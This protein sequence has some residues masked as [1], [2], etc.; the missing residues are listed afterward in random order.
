M[1]ATPAP[2]ICSVEG[3]GAPLRATN[4]IGRC[5]EHAYVPAAGAVCGADGCGTVLRKDNTTGF[6]TPHKRAKSRGPVPKRDFSGRV[7]KPRTCPD[8][9]VDFS[10]RSGNDER[11]PGCQHPHRLALR[12]ERE[13]RNDRDT[14]SVPGCGAK[15]RTSNTTGRCSDHRYYAGDRPVCAA[16]GCEQALRKDNRTG[17]CDAHKYAKDREP[18][19]YCGAPNCD[20]QIRT[21]N[22]TGYCSDHIEPYWRTREYLDKR[23]ADYDAQPKAPDTRRTCSADGCERKIRSDNTTGRCTD[24]AFIHIDWAVCSVDGCEARIRP[25][26]QLGRCVEHRGLYWGGDPPKCGEPG[27]GR[28]LHRD[29]AVGFCH[30]HRAAWREAYNRD[31]YEQTQD[32]RREY[33]RQYREVYADEHRAAASARRGAARSGMDDADLTLSAAYR[34]AILHDPCW[35][36]GSPVTDHVD[37]FFPIAKGGREFWFNLRRACSKCNH[38][39]YDRCGTAYLL[40]RGR[41]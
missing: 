31:Y 24:H 26:N 14:C 30:E 10:P 17:Y 1:Q 29:N 34:L 28:K 16:D 3:C 35:Y 7:F 21:D 8:C 22:T 2:R 37:H 41:L 18:A 19:R 6:C 36:C 25:D 40:R 13:G 9:G 27:C 38:A 33:A 20:R 32:E 11:C 12:A 4:T 5:R 23:K 15:L 39:K